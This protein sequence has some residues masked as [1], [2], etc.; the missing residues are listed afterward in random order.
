MPERGFYLIL[1]V[2]IFSGIQLSGFDQVHW[3]LY[4]PLVLLI[5]ALAYGACPLF[6]LVKEML[7]LR[8]DPQDGAT[9]TTSSSDSQ[10][11]RDS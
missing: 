11:P 6:I 2:L 5:S 3:L 1:L 4:I 7:H 10:A 9:K 8:H